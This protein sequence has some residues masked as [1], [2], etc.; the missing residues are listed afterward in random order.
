MVHAE[1]ILPLHVAKALWRE[2][3][4][5]YVKTQHLDD[6]ISDYALPVAGANLCPHVGIQLR[7]RRD[8]HLLFTLQQLRQFICSKRRF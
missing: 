7:I 5:T 6:E 8:A 2:R 3:T 4:Q 1:Q